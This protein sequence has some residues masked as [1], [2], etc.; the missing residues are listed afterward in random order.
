MR[1]VDSV[2]AHW[3]VSVM[4][5]WPILVS[6]TIATVVSGGRLVLSLVDECS[7]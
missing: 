2:L 1:Y 3:R 6:G 4:T 7:C 5:D